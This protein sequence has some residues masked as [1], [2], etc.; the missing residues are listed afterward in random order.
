MQHTTASKPRFQSVKLHQNEAK[1]Y[2][3][4]V[5]KRRLLCP[6]PTLKH[7]FTLLNGG[8][9]ANC[10]FHL[11]ALDGHNVWCSERLLLVLDRQERVGGWASTH[12]HSTPLLH[13]HPPLPRNI[14]LCFS[15]ISGRHPLK[16]LQNIVSNASFHTSM[17]FPLQYSEVLFY[18]SSKWA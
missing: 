6:P 15:S 8:S 1:K 17:L 11:V 7:S 16:L 14:P 4:S 2:Q 9:V 5:V 12:S 18:C 3:S 13:H 10:W